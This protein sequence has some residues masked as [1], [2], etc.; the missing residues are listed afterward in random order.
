MQR[1]PV[2][3]RERPYVANRMILPKAHRLGL[4]GMG[5]YKMKKRPLAPQNSVR[6]KEAST[7]SHSVVNT[8][9]IL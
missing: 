6:R 3:A 5:Q 2:G 8:S 9:H 1:T 4:K 7:E